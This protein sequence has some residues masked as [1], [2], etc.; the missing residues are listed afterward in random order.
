MSKESTYHSENQLKIDEQ[1]F[2]ELYE[3]YWKKLYHIALKYL[4]DSFQAEEVVQELF[5]S[6]WQRKDTLLLFEDTV[7]NYLVRAVRF[8][9]ARIYSDEVRRTK[10]IDEFKQRQATSNNLTEKQVLYNFL[11]EDVDKLVNLLPDRCKDVYQL[12][13]TKGLNNREI[14]GNLLISEKTVENQLTKALNFIRNGLKR[15]PRT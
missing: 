8:R 5:T 10:K 14:A 6:L 7:E 12:S 9:I 15:Y 4:G 1:T 11:Q 2:F 3:F 13:R